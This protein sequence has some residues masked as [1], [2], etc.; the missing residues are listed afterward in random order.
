[1]YNSSLIAFSYD[2]FLQP[3]GEGGG[4]KRRKGEKRRKVFEIK[5]TPTE[6]Y[7]LREQSASDAFARRGK[8]GEAFSLTTV[9]ESRN[10]YY[11]VGWG[12]WR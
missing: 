4:G 1:M 3:R 6:A 12:R 11:I 7:S 10:L 5:D 2:R 8:N 9:R